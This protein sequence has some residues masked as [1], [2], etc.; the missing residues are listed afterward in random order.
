[1]AEC[2]ECVQ[3]KNKVFENVT[4]TTVT[5]SQANRIH[6]GSPLLMTSFNIIYDY[7]YKLD[8]YPQEKQSNNFRIA[9][10][11]NAL[12]STSS[13]R[14]QP[15]S[16][17]H[18]PCLLYPVPSETLV[19]FEAQSGYVCIRCCAFPSSCN[20]V[21]LNKTRQFVI[22]LTLSTSTSYFYF[23]FLLHLTAGYIVLP[24]ISFLTFLSLFE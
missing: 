11:N 17:E 20:F 22:V 16:T 23:F 12:L 8:K 13:Q 19:L 9:Y 24:R 6:L 5:D 14:F 18:P 4:I 21:N 15:S 3:L 10:C 7:F 2:N 1:M